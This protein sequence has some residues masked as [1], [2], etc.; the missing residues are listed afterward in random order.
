M[1]LRTKDRREQLPTEISGITKGAHAKIPKTHT[2]T[3][4]NP[5]KPKASAGQ[6][7]DLRSLKTEP[8]IKPQG[9]STSHRNTKRTCPALL[10]RKVSK[11]FWRTEFLLKHR[12]PF[13][14]THTFPKFVLGQLCG[15]SGQPPPREAPPA[16][17]ACCWLFSCT[18]LAAGYKIRD[19]R[20]EKKWSKL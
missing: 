6:G 5:A 14:S 12:S 7:H 4:N 13:R 11:H 18:W 20:S 10:P 9:T 15:V 1:C 16:A 19:G 3:Q 8:G 17:P 2:K